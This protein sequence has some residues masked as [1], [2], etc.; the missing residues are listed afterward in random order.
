M[1]NGRKLTAIPLW[2]SA[3]ALLWPWLLS[4][5]IKNLSINSHLHDKYSW[6]AL[7]KSL[8]PLSTAEISRHVHNFG[9]LTLKT[10]EQCPFKW[11]IFT[12][13]FIE[14]SPPSTK[15]SRSWCEIG[16]NGRPDGRP[17]NRNL[18]A[19]YCCRRHNDNIM[20][21][22]PTQPPPLIFQRQLRRTCC[23]RVYWEELSTFEP[24]GLS[25]LESYDESHH[26]LQP[27]PKTID[28]LQ[29]RLLT[30]WEQ[31]PQE[32]INKA[33]HA[34]LQSA[35]LPAWLLM[36]WWSLR[37]SAVT[38]CVSKSASSSHHQLTGSQTLTFLGTRRDGRCLWLK[39][40]NFVIFRYIPTKLRGKVCILLLNSFVKCHAKFKR[41]VAWNIN[42]GHPVQELTLVWLQKAVM[43]NT[44]R[45]KRHRHSTDQ[46]TTSQCLR[47]LPI[48]L[49]AADT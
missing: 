22:Q 33:V 17:G 2:K 5:V 46:D 9:P 10:F 24:A 48:F 1:H 18:S 25:H 40:H 21:F 20:S 36:G 43:F 34:T 13:S 30:I 6:K 26:K 31:L 29:S 32:H 16:V 45:S 11:Q 28:E 12:P 7:L 47:I 38:L 35:W 41:T 27:K 44:C 19:Y 49:Y 42:K 14:I 8:H 37:A 23:K 4:C 15:I 39:Q 3:L